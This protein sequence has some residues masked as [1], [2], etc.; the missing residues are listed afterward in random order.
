MVSFNDT[1]RYNA[2]GKTSSSVTLL[3]VPALD[4]FFTSADTA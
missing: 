4:S 3:G 2:G 1:P